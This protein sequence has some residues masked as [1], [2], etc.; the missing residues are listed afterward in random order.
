MKNAAASLLFLVILFG[1]T[2]VPRAFADREHSSGDLSL[3][4]SSQ[5]AD[6]VQPGETL[7]FTA[8]FE[9]TSPSG[10]ALL[11]LEI[12]DSS[13]HKVGQ[14]YADRVTIPSHKTVT[15]T[16]TSS[17]DLPAGTY[18]LSV[19]I[20][21]P[22]WNGVIHWY[23]HIR[24]FTVGSAGQISLVRIDRPKINLPNG[25]T[26]TIAPTL[27][28]TGVTITDAT[29]TVSLWRGGNFIDDEIFTG[30]TL[31]Q[32]VE[33]TFSFT[34]IPLMQG[35]YTIKTKVELGSALLQNFADLGL[36]VVNP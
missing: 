11:D 30:Q 6:S 5:T 25:S 1:L 32:N 23:D 29:V 8:M 17:A 28:N 35:S 4:S 20:F 7:T 31:E 33:K 22:G 26:A 36:I 27:I 3:V 12:Y 2:H 16:I 24:S 18:F 9:S 19:G 13:G 34:T 10:K 21:N 14:T 15:R